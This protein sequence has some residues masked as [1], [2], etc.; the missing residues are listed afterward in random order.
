MSKF[1]EKVEKTCQENQKVAM[2]IDM[3]GTI[4]V[5]NVYP[6]DKVAEKMEEDYDNAEPLKD[7]IKTLNQLIEKTI[8]EI[9]VEDVLR[10]IRQKEFTNLAVSKAINFLKEDVFVGELYEGELLE[11]VSE[12]DSSFLISYADDLK[13]IIKNALVKSETRDW[14]YAGEEEEFKDMI[15]TLSKKIM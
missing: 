12:M 2:F 6:E 3:D 1:I 15:D 11:K 9:T 14:I 5:Y 4:A 7:I 8:A 10:M 13:N